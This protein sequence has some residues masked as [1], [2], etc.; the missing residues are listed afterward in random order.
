MHLLLP[1]QM[2]HK[3]AP[4]QRVGGVN[5]PSGKR[6]GMPAPH[7]PHTKSMRMASGLV[8]PMRTMVPRMVTMRPVRVDAPEN[9]CEPESRVEGGLAMHTW[10]RT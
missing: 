6:A 7:L 4:V 1:I 9:Q 8:T 2:W 10:H 5:L 3:L